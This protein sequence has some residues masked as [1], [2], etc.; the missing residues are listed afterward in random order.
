M[1]AMC[2]VAR[3]DA[4]TEIAGDSEVETTYLET[5][6]HPSSEEEREEEQESRI[7]SLDDPS[8]DGIPEERLARVSPHAVHPLTAEAAGLTFL[9]RGVEEAEVEEVYNRAAAAVASE[10]ARSAVAASEGAPSEAAESSE[11][12][13]AVAALAP[14]EQPRGD[15]D[16]GLGGEG[17]EEGQ[18]HEREEEEEVQ[19]GPQRFEITV[20][21]GPFGLNISVDNTGVGIQILEIKNGGAMERHNSSVRSRRQRI[22]PCD[23]VT[24]VN[25]STDMQDMLDRIKA[26]LVLQLELLRPEPIWIKVKR[27][28]KPW[29][30]NLTYQNISS[31][32]EIVEVVDGAIRD[33]N[34]TAPEEL[35]VRAKDFI[36]S[37]NGMLGV[38][39]MLTCLKAGCAEVEMK[40]LRMGL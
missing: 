38:E 5:S 29:G 15:E 4:R 1:F 34:E 25:G 24:V 7:V 19:N 11:G 27:G 6:S 39:K 16:E 18:G 31:H 23:V 22:L 36:E 14:P 37:V 8:F 17:E 35:Q 20:D 9:G 2:C 13:A 12:S 21:R 40:V 26:D 3:P 10:A 33:Y 28:G 32:I 30:L